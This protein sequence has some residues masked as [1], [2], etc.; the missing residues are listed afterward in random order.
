MRQFYK[1]WY[2]QI[3]FRVIAF[4]VGLAIDFLTSQFLSTKRIMV[5]TEL[6][7]FSSIVYCAVSR[8]RMRPL[9]KNL[10]EKGEDVNT[11][12]LQIFFGS[13]YIEILFVIC[14]LL[15]TFFN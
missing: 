10:L 15:H 8:L 12:A 5:F 13:A 9:A 3:L 2:V 7:I 1:I 4:L 14:V 11:F 6:C